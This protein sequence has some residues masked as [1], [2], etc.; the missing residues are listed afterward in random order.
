METSIL[1]I[2]NTWFLLIRFYYSIVIWTICIVVV[3]WYYVREVARESKLLITNIEATISEDEYQYFIRRWN[4]YLLFGFEIEWTVNVDVTSFAI[5]REST[6]RVPSRDLVHYI[7]DW[8][9][10][11]QCFYYARKNMKYMLIF[12]T[13]SFIIFINSWLFS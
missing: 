4:C 11:M 8:K 6:F 7:W 12:V 1:N 2:N 13:L 5:D 10:Y 3:H 9:K